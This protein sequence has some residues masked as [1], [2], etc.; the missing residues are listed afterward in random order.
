MRS[1]SGGRDAPGRLEPN[2]RH[3]RRDPE[4]S[5]DARKEL[6]VR[7]DIEDHRQEVKRRQ[8]GGDAPVTVNE[9]GDHADAA[10]GD[11]PGDPGDG[12]AV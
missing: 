12:F 11:A 5:E 7:H 3:V 8:D 10:F 1:P 2:D 9:G 6:L 4:A